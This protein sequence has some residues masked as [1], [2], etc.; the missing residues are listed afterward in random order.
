MSD[1]PHTAE[2]LAAAIK[3]ENDK[4]KG[5]DQAALLRGIR[6]VLSG[7][8]R[9]HGRFGKAMIAQMLGGSQNK[10]I[11]QWKLNRLSTYGMLSGLKQP[12]LIDL[13]DATISAGMAQQIEVDERRPTVQLTEFGE[14]VMHARQPLPASLK[15]SFPLAKRL[16]VIAASI[17]GGDVS[18][19]AAAAGGT[20]QNSVENDSDPGSAI[21]DAFDSSDIGT[22]L[23]IDASDDDTQPASGHAVASATGQMDEDLA[24]RLKRWRGKTAAALGV[25][26]YRVLTNATIQRLA[27]DRPGSTD[28]LE[29]IHGIG[30]TTVEQFGYDLIRLI[31]DADRETA[32]VAQ[33]HNAS[34]TILEAP[35]SV[36]RS[37]ASPT[38]PKLESPPNVRVEVNRVQ[39]TNAQK[40]DAYWTWRMLRDGY[41]WENVMLIRRKSSDDVLED[42]IL[43]ATAG[44]DVD[45]SW[46]GDGEIKR[47][48]EQRLEEIN[49]V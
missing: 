21:D 14:E 38:T 26:A 40:Q 7:I 29:M 11:Q 42:L 6:I 22:D 1:T 23:R 27:T 5:L 39:A 49:R 43:T 45:A 20:S 15:L 25:P 31:N 28:E 2:S 33:T 19:E 32:E 24:N 36:S 30:P 46:A 34:P 35:T 37:Q 12:D 13:L 3:V 16:S 17:E 4:Y 10:K 48:L 44:H 8:K 9:M 47:K 41:P 18:G